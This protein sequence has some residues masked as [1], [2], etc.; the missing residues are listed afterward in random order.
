MSMT[1]LDLFSMP[2]TKR[3]GHKGKYITLG[4]YGYLIKVTT[5][6]APSQMSEAEVLYSNVHEILKDHPQST[7]FAPFFYSVENSSKIKGDVKWIVALSTIILFLIYFV[8]LRDI[9]LLSHTF[10]ALASSMLF[11]T[12]VCTTTIENFGVLSLAFG[13]S[14][15]AVSIDYFFHYYF[16]N[17]YANSK[18][19]ERSVFYGFM[20]TVAA[21][22][23]L[24][25]IPVPMISQISTFALLSLSFA[26]VLFTFVF[27]Y[28]DIKDIKAQPEQ[29]TDFKKVPAI[30][31]SITSLILLAYSVN[32][33]T[34]DENIK[35]LDYQNS[36]LQTAQKLFE[37]TGD[38]KLYPVIVQGESEE[39]LLSRLHSLKKS[40]ET[41]FSF[42]NFV[43]EK[44]ICESKIKKLNK[45]DFS[46]LNAVVNEEASRI[47]FK[48]NYFKGAY[49]FT[50]ELP[51]CEGKNLDIFKSLN[52]WIYK[53]KEI[54][55][56]IALVQNKTEAL[57]ESYI[58]SINVKEIFAQVAQQMLNDI[59]VYSVIVLGVI[60]CVLL[61]SVRRRFFYALNYILFPLGVTLSI[62]VSLH[63]VNIMHLFSFI[64]LIAIGID[65]GIYMSNSNKQTQTVLAI[66]YS[67]LSTFA[68]FGV[69]VFSSITALSSIGIVI[70]LGVS[71]IY[72]LTKVMR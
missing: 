5:K 6:V 67:L 70:S 12:L 1:P 19:F 17:F 42:A 56:T 4:D 23:V 43:V 59:V 53:S 35:N 72:I 9:K 49:D 62:V 68:A 48:K 47:G 3:S 51:S 44:E 65:Y 55:Y 33:F 10:V 38:K 63:E 15:T 45:Y 25:F 7:A 18:R 57:R 39:E 11:A 40:Q 28:I 13:T 24:S 46:S 37:Q 61:L 58:S 41:T 32:S 21:F 31:V 60:F 14:L 36:K 29:K 22:F 71:S 52:L 26:Y 66:K 30:V 64:I 2:T 8:M 27:K 16:H 54:I 34:F 69:L 50:K 20:T